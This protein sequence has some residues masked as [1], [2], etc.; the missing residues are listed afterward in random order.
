M[1]LAPWRT[2]LT[3]ALYRNRLPN[4][5]YFQLATV[6]EDGM[7]ANRTVVF[8]GFLNETNNLKIVTDIRS[9]KAGQIESQPWG[10]ICWYFPKTR[11][12]F[13]LLGKMILVSQN[14]ENA[15]LQK[16][17][18]KTWEELSDGA[19]IQFAWPDPGKARA[20]REAF[21]PALPNAFEPLE[22]FCLLLLEPTKVEHLELRGE[23]QNRRIYYL[24]DQ[25]NWLEKEVNP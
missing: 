16:A 14:H 5:R 22:N 7:P 21:S 11:E 20:S 24:D 8:R 13:R 15:E 2:L 17:R 25:Q 18:Q 3:H 23:P 19:R 4:A 12:Q 10:E 9:E 6:R 1:L